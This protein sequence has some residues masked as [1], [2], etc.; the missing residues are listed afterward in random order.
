MN[1]LNPV[2]LKNPNWT[3]ENQ[4]EYGIQVP[5]GKCRKCRHSYVQD[6]VFRM[7][8]ELEKS[9]TAYFITLTY[10]NDNLPRTRMGW[11][12]LVKRDIQLYFK[13]LRKRQHKSSKRLKYYACGEYGSNFGRPH[14]HAIIFNLDQNGF[15]NL[16]DC[17]TIRKNSKY[18]NIGFVDV[19]PVNTAR[20]AYVASYTMKGL[21]SKIKFDREKDDRQPEFNLMS[22]KLGATWFEDHPERV[23]FM[24]EKLEPYIITNDGVKKRIPRYFKKK[25]FSDEE[26]MVLRTKA[27]EFR[28]SQETPDVITRRERRMAYTLNAEKRELTKKN[29][30]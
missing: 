12:T 11:P 6:W 14:Y 24:K 7:E 9:D 19:R 17:W 8:A 21:K 15:Q 16:Q 2:T 26:Q 27:Q 25:I 28:E 10:E 4:E 5:C 3:L 1:C 20:L 23:K 18:I 22:K 29:Q 30:L 13:R